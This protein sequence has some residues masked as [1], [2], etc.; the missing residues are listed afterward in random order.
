M[1]P[2]SSSCVSLLLSVV[3]LLAAD[4]QTTGSL[5]TT[6]NRDG[7]DDN[8]KLAYTYDELRSDGP[9][10]WSSVQSIPSRGWGEWEVV[11]LASAL[12]NEENQPL[13]DWWTQNDCGSEPRPSPIEIIPNQECTDTQELLL[14]KFNP[15]VDCRHPLENNLRQDGTAATTSPTLQSCRYSG[16]AARSIV[17]Y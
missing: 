2:S 8:Y 3:A 17:Y 4:A 11:R 5:D 10:K 16:C 13:L 14:R 1:I 9:S 7:W 15:A 12:T 6:T